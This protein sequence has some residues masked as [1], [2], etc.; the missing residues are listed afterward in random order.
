MTVV[1]ETRT[2]HSDGDDVE[3]QL[4]WIAEKARKDPKCKF[5]GLFYL[6]NTG[7]PAGC[8]EGRRKDSVSGIDGVAKEKSGNDLKANRTMPLKVLMEIVA[9]KLRWHFAYYGVSDNARK[10]RRFAA[11]VRTL[12]Y[13]WLNRRSNRGGHVMGELLQTPQEVSTAE[14]THQGKFTHDMVNIT[15]KSRVRQ[16]VSERPLQSVISSREPGLLDSFS[17]R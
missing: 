6:V 12:P 15:M 17:V 9:A 4:Q 2:V 10:M 7:S 13:R 8:F 16:G 14:A 5:T 3:T 11:E 1:G